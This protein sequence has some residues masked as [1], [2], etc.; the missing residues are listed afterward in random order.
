[1]L[2]FPQCPP[3][4][5]ET[6]PVQVMPLAFP[7]GRQ[8]TFPQFYLPCIFFC[9]MELHSEAI[10]WDKSSHLPADTLMWGHDDKTHR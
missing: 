4:P 2:T 9:R 1:M 10:I 6:S 7:E 3:L 8:T 5:D